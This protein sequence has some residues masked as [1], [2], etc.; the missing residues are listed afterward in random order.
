MR[1]VV[2]YS[3]QSDLPNSTNRGLIQSAL[4][5][6]AEAIAGD[7][8]VAVEPVVDRDTEGIAGSPDI[9]STIFGKIDVSDI[10]VAD[11]SIVSDSSAKRQTPNP[12]VIIEVGFALKALNFERGILVFNS[13]FGTIESLPFDLRMRRLDI[14]N[15]APEEKDRA[16]ARAELARKLEK[17]LR[18]ALPLVPTLDSAA[19]SVPAVEGIEN[20]RPNRRIG[21]RAELADIL[22]QLDELQPRK[23]RDGGA[24]DE[25]F[26]AIPQTQ[27]SI[28]RFSK[29]AEVTAV[30][31]DA[32]ISEELYNWFGLILGAL[33]PAARL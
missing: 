13:A 24:P 14:Y 6:A 11:I 26:Q 19:A 12:N 5:I 17:A 28:A 31:G 32:N 1:R 22:K 2:F 29:M 10:V 21:V 30:M 33:F 16:T 18:S 3:W 9:A 15:A 27:T 20:Q 4:E 8:S 7:D 25:L 23:M